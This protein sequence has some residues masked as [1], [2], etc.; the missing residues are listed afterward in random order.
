MYLKSIFLSWRYSKQETKMRKEDSTKVWPLKYKQILHIEHHDFAM[1]P[2]FGGE[3][4][5]YKIPVL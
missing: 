2:G 3:H 5:L 1:R 4:Y